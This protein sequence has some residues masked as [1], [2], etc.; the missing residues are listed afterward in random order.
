LRE[1]EA[2]A[3][4]A[5]LPLGARRRKLRPPKMLGDAFAES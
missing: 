3:P 4:L 1:I 2:F 5:R